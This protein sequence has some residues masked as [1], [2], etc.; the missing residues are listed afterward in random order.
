MEKQVVILGAGPAG[1]TAAYELTRRGIRSTVLE[2][3]KLVGGLARTEIFKGYR[4]DIGG[5][6]F[7]TKEPQVSR[8]WHEI[9]GADFREIPRLSRIYYRG[10]YYYYP[11]RLLNAFLGLG[12]VNSIWITLSY[13]RSRLFPVLPEENFEDFV[14]NRF[15]KRLYFI[16]FKT[17]TEKVWGIP[18]TEI[19][20]EWAA[21][22]IRGL[23]FASAVF[24]PLFSP[25]RRQIRT[26][27]EKFE[28]PRLGPGMM[29]DA[30]KEYV[31]SHGSRVVL[32]APVVRV[33]R[34][35]T[36]VES[37]IVSR[38]G[39]E[40]QMRGT[41][42][43]STLPLHDLIARIDPP[44]PD[45]VLF[46]AEGLKY[47]DLMTVLLIIDRPNLFPD[48][49]IYVHTPNVRVGR[50]QNFKNWS[51]DMVPDP[52]MTSLGMEYF[53]FEGD[54]LWTLPDSDLIEL[55]KRELESLR[56]ANARDVV[57]GTVR[58]MLK[59]YPVYDS[60]YRENLNVVRGYLDSLENFQ[61]VGRN[62]MHKYNNQD[63]SMMTALLAARNICGEKNIVWNVNTDMEYQE[64]I[65]IYSPRDNRGFGTS[66]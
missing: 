9:L 30:V 48:N 38:S 53:V 14:T 61:T 62:G 7:F 50:I 45:D 33:N 46:A 56:L 42:F 43:I 1:L 21:Q 2:A 27:I 66:T 34:H 64:E 12:I 51:P 65:R 40:E 15:G 47:R 59:A 6:R 10:R 17:Y 54:D 13:L 25:G 8:I 29:W 20:A 52:K 39:R 60:S 11:I 49:W 58:R 16:F 57:D 5:H 24:N 44:P 55:A 63:H 3:D 35:D 22:R 28:Y 23:S 31:E 4:F 36:Q 19:R 41:H 26:L 37:V 18:S 32:E